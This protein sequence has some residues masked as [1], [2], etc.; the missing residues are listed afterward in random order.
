MT[1]K[2]KDGNVYVLE[3]PNKLVKDQ[4]KID[5]DKCVFHNFTWNEIIWKRESKVKSPDLKI[6]NKEII[7][8][9]QETSKFDIPKVNIPKEEIKEVDSMPK[10][11]EMPPIEVEETK[12]EF[13]LPL[14]KVKVLMH[15]L[16]VKIREN[17]DK[18][19]GESWQTIKYGEKFIFPSVMISNND[20]Q[21]EFWTSD[22]KN[23][24][25]EKSI[26]YPFS[27]EIYNQEIDSYDR[28]PFD[29]YRWWKVV[30][31]EEKEGGYLFTTAPSQDHPDFSD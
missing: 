3:G 27:Y 17:K 12:E 5:L 31:K 24:I 6:K 25:L 13:K 18:F 29:E 30:K 11:A 19:Y 1:I 2:K 15:C 14:L 20:L 26:V 23:Q 4:Q 7:V 28:V 22:P 16:P 9:S 21:M 10:E 8:P